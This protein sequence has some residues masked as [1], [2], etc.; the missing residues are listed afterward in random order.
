MI[1]EIIR[2]SG[3]LKRERWTFSPFLDYA[4][5]G[6]YFDYYCFETLE[7]PRH[8]NWQTQTHWARLDKRNNNIDNP[9]LPLDVEAEVRAEI[10][11]HVANWEIIK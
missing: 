5:Q 3:D 1:I 4:K 11:K 7:T 8:K 6:I 10:I 9:P 2:N